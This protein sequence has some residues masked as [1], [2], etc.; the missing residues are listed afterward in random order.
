MK[1]E[2]M[3]YETTKEFIL[4]AHK[5]ACPDWKEKIEKEF[6]DLFKPDLFKPKH[7]INKWYKN[8][9]NNSIFFITAINSIAYNDAKGYGLEGGVWLDMQNNFYW[10]TT[11]NCTPSTDEEVFSMLKKEAEKRGYE[12][13]NFYCL[14]RNILS[15][16]DCITKFNSKNN[17]FWIKYGCVFHNGKWAT[18]VEQPKEMTL[19]EIE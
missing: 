3:K 1:Y 19:Q 13:G 8:D 4:D 12:E 2:T 9:Y 18:I 5:D 10:S 15:E 14:Y 16:D 6:P 11:K 17:R 7:E